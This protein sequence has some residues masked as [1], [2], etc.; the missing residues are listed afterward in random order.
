MTELAKFPRRNGL[1]RL[2]TLLFCPKG[3]C[4]G[5]LIGCDFHA[6]GEFNYCTALDGSSICIRFGRCRL[7][8]FYRFLKMLE[9]ALFSKRNDFRYVY[10]RASDC[11]LYQHCCEPVEANCVKRYYKRV[12]GEGGAAG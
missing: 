2:L 12:N 11:L 7:R 3:S 1:G 8:Y 10:G 4:R 6:E 9:D 5:F